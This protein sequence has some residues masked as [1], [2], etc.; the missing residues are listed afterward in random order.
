MADTARITLSG[1]R[2]GSVPLKTVSLAPGGLDADVQ[3]L[4]AA[5]LGRTGTNEQAVLAILT[6]NRAPEARQALQAAFQAKYGQSL[7]SALTAELSLTYKTRALSLLKTGQEPTGINAWRFRAE[8]ALDAVDA[9][10][11]VFQD[12]PIVASLATGVTLVA[13]HKYPAATAALNYTLLATSAARVVSN[14][15]Q[16]ARATT[17]GERNR[18]L[19]QS[20]RASADLAMSLPGAGPSGMKLVRGGVQTA[21]TSFRAAEGT[22]LARAF[23]AAKAGAAY[24]LPVTVV[25]PLNPRQTVAGTLGKTG[26]MGDMARNMLAQYGKDMTPAELIEQ[27]NKIAANLGPAKQKALLAIVQDPKFLTMSNGE[28]LAKVLTTLGPAHTK[29]GQ[30]A[31]TTPGLPPEVAN[32]LGQLQ[33]GLEPMSEALLQE[34]MVSAGLAGKYE[35]GKVVGVASM[36]Q[37]NMARNTTTGE[38]VV[39]KFLKPGITRESIQQEFKLMQEVLQPALKRMKPNEAADLRSQLQAFESGIL[40]EMDMANEAKNMQRFAA[41]YGDHP[42]FQGITMIEL[43]AD[44]KAL[45]MSKAPGLSFRKL[46]PQSVEARQAGSAYLRGIADQVFRHGYYH[47]D[48]HPGNVFWDANA[49]KVTFL[50]MGAVAEV[51]PAQRLSLQKTILYVLAKDADHLAKQ[52]VSEASSI[53]G[54]AV[55]AQ[56]KLTA[57]LK[58]YLNQPD[59][60]MAKIDDHLKALDVIA[61]QQGVRPPDQGFWLTKSMITAYGVFKHASGDPNVLKECLPAVMAG[62][63]QSFKQ[64][65]AALR[66]SLLDVA[67]VL[68][69]RL[70]TLL[71]SLQELRVLKPELF[72]MYPGN[73]LAGIT[74]ITQTELAAEKAL[75]VTGGKPIGVAKP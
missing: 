66:S 50:D 75:A 68:G 5:T 7:E 23:R 74:A 29:L 24:R 60:R 13:A 16:A 44:K 1:N 17:P 57:A 14:E 34:R 63:L 71:Q 28:R 25:A 27:V 53:E 49:A 58:T 19:Q 64:N 42:D 32:A 22:L 31:A 40:E 30:V 6:K 52:M 8:G 67:T 41:Q 61:K 35:I 36:G 12:H 59:F 69:T 9:L 38:E 18:Y 72:V 51:S 15:V 21:K 43:G 47:A 55:E 65:P 45:V 56:A 11:T 2:N 37:V 73:F 39:I 46:E 54:S 33:D 20:G 10:G 3:A 4:H 48:P 70:P 26:D 62:L